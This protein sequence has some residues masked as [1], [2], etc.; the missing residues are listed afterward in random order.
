MFDGKVVIVTGAGSGIGRAAARRFAEEGGRVCVADLD[1]ASAEA[2]VGSITDAGGE[3]FAMR[4][5]VTSLA[6]NER[7]VAETVSRYGGIDVAFL[8]AGFYGPPADPLDG[9]P[10]AFDRHIDINL[11]GVFYGARCTGRA[12]REGGAIVVTASTAGFLGIPDYTG[13]CASKHGAIGVVRAMAPVL[14]KR[15]VR[16]NAICPGIVATPMIGMSDLPPLDPDPDSLP[17]VPFRG[18]GRP[19]HVAEFA[20]YLASNRGAFINGGAHVIDAGLTSGFLINE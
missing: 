14:A 9:D 2:A 17:Q 15:N 5:D 4:V 18:A 12:M 19:E 10:A 3:A 7:M 8:N 1:A 16:I 11:R 13:Y 20:L 6:D